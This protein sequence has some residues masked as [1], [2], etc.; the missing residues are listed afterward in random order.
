MYVKPGNNNPKSIPVLAVEAL[1]ID[2]GPL[3]TTRAFVDDDTLHKWENAGKDHQENLPCCGQRDHNMNHSEQ[4]ILLGRVVGDN[5]GAAPPPSEGLF[6]WRGP[7]SERRVHNQQILTGSSSS[8]S[9]SSS[10]VVE[11]NHRRERSN[12]QSKAHVC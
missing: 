9:S 5:D 4:S 11:W 1:P 2:E 7:L 8:S 3:S 10:I 12:S 6:G